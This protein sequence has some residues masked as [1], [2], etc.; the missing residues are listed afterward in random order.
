ML[1][2]NRR[3]CLFCYRFAP[4]VTADHL[5]AALCAIDQLGRRGLRRGEM[6]LLLDFLAVRRFEVDAAAIQALALRRVRSV[7]SGVDIR[8]AHV[9][10]GVTRERMHDFYRRNLTG[11]SITTRRFGCMLEALFW[12]EAQAYSPNDAEPVLVAT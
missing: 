11:S 1:T 5:D 4:V 6:R 8:S 12:L 3:C 10:S 9:L 7:P 2:F